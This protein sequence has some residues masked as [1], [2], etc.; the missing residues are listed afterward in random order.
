MT[1]IILKEKFL[2]KKTY[3]G[4]LGGVDENGKILLK[5]EEHEIKFNFLEIEKANIDL[6]WAIKNNQL[7]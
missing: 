5:T 6:N 1:K 7:N 3:K 2:G 4:F